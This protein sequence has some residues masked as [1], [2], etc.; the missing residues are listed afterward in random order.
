MGIE[1]I[2]IDEL[3]EKKLEHFKELSDL[4]KI[5]ANVKTSPLSVM[6]HPMLAEIL[7]GN[8]IS[9]AIKHNLE[10]GLLQIKAGAGQL[11]VEN[12]GKPLSGNPEDL[13]RRF[14]KDDQSAD[15][16]GLGLAIVK[17]ICNSYGFRIQYSFYDNMHSIAVFF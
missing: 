2:Q 15:S 9:N 7:V 6:L 16:L 1:N 17:E 5:K 3:V 10:G 8:L 14:K 12:S 11:V 13:F 4:K